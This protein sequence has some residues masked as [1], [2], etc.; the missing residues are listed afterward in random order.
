[1]AHLKKWTVFALGILVLLLGTTS[2]TLKYRHNVVKPGEPIK[3]KYGF[4]GFLR[5]SG[6]DNVAGDLETPVVDYQKKGSNV[7]IR[8][9]G[10]VHIGDKEYYQALQKILD[11]S[12][13]VL[14][15]GV[16]FSKDKRKVDPTSHDLYGL[17][18]EIMG[19]T[20]QLGSINYNR[21]HW[22][23]CDRMTDPRFMP[24][25][26]G[27]DG[28]LKS[29][30]QL[31]ETQRKAFEKLKLRERVRMVKRELAPFIS[32]FKLE[33]ILKH[34][35]ALYMIQMKDMG[36]SFENGIQTLKKVKKVLKRLELVAP[37]NQFIRQA[38]K[39]IETSIEIFQKQMKMQIKML[40][41]DRNIY[42]MEALEKHLKRIGNPK[43]PFTLSV[44]YGVAHLH[45][46]DQRLARLGYKPVKKVWIKAWRIDSR[47]RSLFRHIPSNPIRK[48][49]IKKVTKQP[50]HTTPSR[51]KVPKT[52]TE[53]PQV[54]GK[55]VEGMFQKYMN[56]NYSQRWKMQKWF[57]KAGKT[58]IPYLKSQMKNKNN[59]IRAEAIRLLGEMKAYPKEVIPSLLEAVEKDKY[60][61]VRQIAAI[62][63]SYY[64]NLS[65]QELER[66]WKI[67]D[68]EKDLNAKGNLSI[69]LASQGDKVFS[70][71]LKRLE[72]SNP[73]IKACASRG[74]YRLAYKSKGNLG[75]S[76]VVP[77]VLKNLQSSNNYYVLAYHA[78]LLG[79]PKMQPYASQIVPVLLQVYKKL[80]SKGNQIRSSSYLLANI[81]RTLGN[82][83]SS[84]K[85][86]TPLLIKDLEKMKNN[87]NKI[88]YIRTLGNIHSHPKKVVPILISELEKFRKK[89]YTHGIQTTLY[90]LREYKQ[91][92]SPALKM[93]LTFLDSKNNGI[94]R[95]AI[96]VLAEMGPKAKAALPKL[97]EIAKSKS[98][99]KWDAKKAIQK[100]EEG[101]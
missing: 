14:Y 30:D 71:F 99:I 74:L 56:A 27:K 45:D 21:K 73:N 96:L 4:Q 88:D 49:I 16:H 91:D 70:G 51:T 69:A 6:Y 86:A 62:Y 7:K 50:R 9:V 28:K 72:S 1:M 84:A 18:G 11:K 80:K 82:L 13:L 79:I 61:Y 39:G 36:S 5:Y 19:M 92:A 98:W 17:I 34:R 32:P 10:A 93:V 81:V 12:D 38:I 90:A 101:N 67:F 83:G 97:R 8:M 44:F 52:G 33:D 25:I 59:R 94:K 23:Q 100:I 77:V 41:T 37:E 22:I 48:K 15:E 3:W 53:Q 24:R 95:A 78:E 2:C 43:K 60:P 35:Y 64:E 31:Y 26:P 54:T 63:L 46:F 66:L 55:A 65:S 76:K 29:P 42:V 58:V 20:D 57:I 87:Y 47:K 75:W 40:I 89:N 68:K 85:D